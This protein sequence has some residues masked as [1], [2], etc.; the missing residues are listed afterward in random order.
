MGLFLSSPLFD[1]RTPHATGVF[2][3]LIPNMKTRHFIKDQA[4][5]RTDTL[6][7]GDRASRGGLSKATG[8]RCDDIGECGNQAGKVR[9][10][11]GDLGGVSIARMLRRGDR[12]TGPLRS[13]FGAPTTAT[14]AQC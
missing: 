10:A 8:W 9:R 3:I 12:S 4:N 11:C 1:R 6:R 7:H 13:P 2:E 5:M 14:K